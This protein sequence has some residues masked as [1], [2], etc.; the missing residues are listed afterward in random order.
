MEGA[1][2]LSES[3]RTAEPV[4]LEDLRARTERFPVFGPAAPDVPDHAVA[5]VPLLLEGRAIGGVV[6]S[7]GEPRTFNERDRAVLL[8]LG[9]Q[10]AQALQRAN[11]FEAERAARAEAERAREQLA[12]LAE[13]SATLSASLDYDRTLARV[14]KLAVPRLADWCSI[15]MVEEDGSLRQLAV[16]HA[17]PAKVRL[18]R[19]YRKRWP[20]HPDDPTGVPAVIR[21]R[22]PEL[23]PEISEEL[24]AAATPDPK[25]RQV[26]RDLQL[27]SVMIVPLQARGTA[28]G[29]ITFVWAES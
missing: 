24:I 27:R 6:L 1:F 9:R 25:L 7:F 15:D 19:Q 16:A 29:A 21:T 4:F 3:V 5:C 22:R 23:Y 26:V 10:C 11:L 18:A 2:P 8:A 17:D 20:P 14:A 28:V 12:F 13:A